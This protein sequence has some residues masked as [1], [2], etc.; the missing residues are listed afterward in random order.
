MASSSQQP[1]DCTSKSQAS[2]DPAVDAES[3]PSEVLNFDCIFRAK[4][5]NKGQLGPSGKR[6]TK[7]GVV[8]E[9]LLC[10]SDQAWS[11]PKRDNAIYHAKRKHSDA[12][13]SSCHDPCKAYPSL[14]A[15]RTGSMRY[16]T[17]SAYHAR[18]TMARCIHQTIHRRS[19]AR[20][21]T[22]TAHGQ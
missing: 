22:I 10:S 21:P 2:I 3:T 19:L 6:R 12:I 8:Y 20:S 14:K 18:I 15:V 17:F 4:Y 13:N 11:N 16:P 1:A 7:G 5:P 9:C